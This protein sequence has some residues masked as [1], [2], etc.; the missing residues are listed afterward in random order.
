M[1]EDL[2]DAAGLSSAVAPTGGDLRTVVHTAAVPTGQLHYATDLAVA[3]IEAA[4]DFLLPRLRDEIEKL[5]ASSA[6]FRIAVALRQLVTDSAAI[7]RWRLEELAADDFFNALSRRQSEQSL[8]NAWNR[9]AEALLPWGREEGYDTAG[10]RRVSHIDALSA[11]VQRNQDETY[12]AK[13][14]ERVR[15]ASDR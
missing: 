6:A 7:A 11:A 2:V 10:W 12:R 3:D 13:L 9:L 15:K 4:L 14:A 5:D 8:L 1:S